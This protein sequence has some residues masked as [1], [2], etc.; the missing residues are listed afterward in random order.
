MTSAYL[1][2]LDELLR[3]GIAG[4]SERFTAQQVRFIESRQ[5]PDGGFAGRKG[6]SD[7][8]YTDFALRTLAWLAPDHTAFARASDYAGIA[9]RESDV[10]RSAARAASLRGA[11]KQGGGIPFLTPSNPPH[12]ARNVVECFN[13]LNVRR[14]LKRHSSRAAQNPLFDESPIVR[15]LRRHCL[16]SGGLARSANESRVSAYHTFLGSL[17]FEMLDVEMPASDGAIRAIADLHRPDGG[18]AELSDQPASQTN[19]AAAA[20]GFLILR[21]ALPPERTTATIRFL[22]EMQS[23]DGGW[24]AHAAV[25][26]GDLL[27]TFTGL[28]TLASLG[29]F[30]AID[31]AAAARFL[32]RMALPAG[33][34][35]ACDGDDSPDV[36]Y[37]HYGVATLAL[38]R[39]LAGE[40]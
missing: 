30:D 16:P 35:L 24:R 38:L 8:Y 18:Y 10:A 32:H 3:P 5:Q 11:A 25:A 29:G 6:G 17:C 26:A 4:F 21:N 34:F 9:I 36:E 13:L 20:I 22:A 33:G 27:S 15:C 23:A 31:S 7:L 12:V 37:A 39:I 14:L 1:D 2:M 40:A 28:F 19:A